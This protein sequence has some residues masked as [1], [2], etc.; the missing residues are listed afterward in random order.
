MDYTIMETQL[1]GRY[2]EVFAKAVLYATMK[3]VPLD[4]A[5]E[6]ISELY[7]LLLT[8]QSE[9]KPVEK[10]IGRDTN[11]FC[12]DFFG[13]CTI[14]DRLKTV[15]AS[16]YRIA[17]FMLVI[18]LISLF[19][20]EDPIGEFFTLKADY[21]GYG[22]GFVVAALMYIVTEAVLAPIFVRSKKSKGT[23]GWYWLIIGMFVLFVAGGAALFGDVSLM[24][25]V[26][27]VIL[28]SAGYILLYVIVRAVWRYKNFGSVFNSRKQLEQD[29]YYRNLENRD[30]EK[31][32]LEGWQKRYER[33]V[34]KSKVTAETYLEKL[35]KE[36]RLNKKMMRVVLP[37][38]IAAICVF[39]IFDVALES[40]W[41]DTLFF[42]LFIG[43]VEFFI[44]RWMIRNEKK[45]S[46]LRT[47][48]LDEC[49]RQ[50]KTLPD[51]IEETLKGF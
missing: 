26:W 42:A 37:L 47:K 14:G 16:L 33:L 50:N 13:D 15:P 51:Y 35:Q 7:D 2:R 8:A 39:C 32:L 17:W 18:E 11:L 9:S 21:S 5:D 23:G 10:L 4:V 38:C 30:L 40:T 36:E 29:S 6:K 25:P 41:H 49:E 48:H 1:T 20:A 31:I 3:N 19:A 34:K 28:G 44:C 27:P 45:N 24:L 22:V 43:A 12:R 46:A